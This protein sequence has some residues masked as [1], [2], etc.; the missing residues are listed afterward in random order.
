MV[1]LSNICQYEIFALIVC[2]RLIWS[3][4]PKPFK[5]SPAWELL[6]GAQSPISGLL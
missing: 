2:D 1:R 6:A 4:F 5:D 3:Q